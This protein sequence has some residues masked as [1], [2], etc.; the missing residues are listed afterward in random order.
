MQFWTAWTSAAFLKAYL[1]GAAGQPFLPGQN[2]SSQLLLDVYLLEKAL[3]EL[4]YELNNRPEW[5]RIPLRGILQ[6]LDESVLSS[7]A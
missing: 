7:P 6:L 4:R 2:E 5:A 3:Y 1:A